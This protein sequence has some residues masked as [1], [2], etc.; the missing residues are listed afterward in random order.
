LLQAYSAITDEKQRSSI[1]EL[2]EEIAASAGGKNG[3]R[4]RR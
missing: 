2:V 3:R 1:L 4:T